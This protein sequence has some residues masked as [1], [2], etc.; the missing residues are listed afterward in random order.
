MTEQIFNAEEG[1][2]LET[3]AQRRGFKTARDFMQALLKQ[4]AEQHGEAAVIESD[5]ELGDPF[6]SFKRGWDDAMNGRVMTYEEFERRM[7]SETSFA[8]DGD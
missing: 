6:E 3:L 8:Q 2:Q 7:Q 5:D 4:D 1:K